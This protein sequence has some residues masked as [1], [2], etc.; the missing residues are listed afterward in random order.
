MLDL[1]KHDVFLV[2]CIVIND[3]NQDNVDNENN[4]EDSYDQRR[5]N[6]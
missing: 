1:I 6:F 4:N 3:K 2:S 5:G